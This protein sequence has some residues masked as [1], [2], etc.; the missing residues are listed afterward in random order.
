VLESETAEKRTRDVRG[1]GE[2]VKQRLKAI[3]K[4]KAEASEQPPMPRRSRAG[5]WARGRHRPATRGN[6]TRARGLRRRAARRVNSEP[7]LRRRRE[8]AKR[9]EAEAEPRKD[10][11]IK[12]SREPMKR[13]K[14][15]RLRGGGQ[16]A[17]A[18]SGDGRAGTSAPSV[19]AEATVRERG[20]SVWT[21][22]QRAASNAAFQR[23]FRC[24]HRDARGGR[25]GA[26]VMVGRGV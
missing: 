26:H 6:K 11:A 14:A 22:R 23:H 4:T 24:E 17:A 13:R 9:N 18:H 5:S 12:P 21:R 19:P 7:K 2:V 20:R 1:S 25:R 3:A 8:S 10:E 15:P 16:P